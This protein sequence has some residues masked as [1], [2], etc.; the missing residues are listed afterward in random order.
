M[1]KDKHIKDNNAPV[2]PDIYGNIIFWLLM[3]AI[4]LVPL[5]F[6]IKSYDQFEMPKLTLL[7]ILTSLMLGTWL[8]K[9][10]SEGRIEY[11][12]MPLD[13]PMLLWALMNIVTT[14]TSFSPHLSFRGE[15][16]NFAGS[17]S[18]LNYVA[19]YFI[20]TQFIKTKKQVNYAALT[21][22]LS[23]LFITVYSLMQFAGFDFI[24]WSDAS[25][26]KGRYFASMGNPNFLGAFI[27]MVIPLTVAFFIQAAKAGKKGYMALLGLLFVGEYIALF[28]TQSRGPF[29][30][31]VFSMAV[32]LIY[33]IKVFLKNSS[34]NSGGLLKAIVSHKIW[35]AAVSAVL[36]IAV[37][38][39]LTAG[40]DATNRIV[41][42]IADIPGSLQQSRLHIWIPAVKMIKDRPVFGYGV[43]TFKAVFP[44]YEGSDF[45]QID[46]A[47]VS[48]RTAH[49]EPLNIAAT[50]GLISLGIYLMMIWLYLLSWYRSFKRIEEYNYR[51][52]SLGF[53]AASVGYLVQNMFSFGVA[54]INTTF[55]LIMAIH[56]L[57]YAAVK[58]VPA[59]VIKLYDREKAGFFAPALMCG[60]AV[61]SVFLCFKAYNVYSADVNYNMGKLY[62]SLHNRWDL[63]VK[64]HE[65]SVEKCP[66]EVKYHVYLGLAYERLAMMYQ[67]KESKVKLLLMAEKAYKRGSELNSMNAYYWGNLGRV[68]TLLGEIQDPKY[69]TLAEEDYIQA[70]K[71]APVT[72]LFYN[73]L[74]DLYLKTGRGDK[75]MPMLEK[76]EMYDKQLAAT[77]N[78]TLGN[79]LFGNRDYTNAL[80]HYKRSFEFKPDFYECLYNIGVT[81]AT[82]GQKQEAIAALNELLLKKPDFKQREDAEK[83]LKDLKK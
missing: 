78:F 53:F 54:A 31:F 24:K 49:N 79:I 10:F 26:I 2:K 48:S 13:I 74:L 3:A 4:F 7:R 28:G 72:A 19:L 51:I 80:Y 38:L 76:I 82:L 68:H 64:Q 18:N 43:D 6:N 40:K 73:N 56:A 34:Q 57:D 65:L 70:V 45:A 11:K 42:S 71:R 61:L 12:P 35:I 16:E 37:I 36:A 69:F 29:L 46:G 5:Y 77:A 39:S 75:I 30:G 55:Y 83:I 81:A 20:A 52:L 67:D 15:Y 60:A 66:G 32:F 17:L 8:V 62:G 23:G 63:A 14:F 47:N 1:A 33:G 44:A 59:A 27:I 58:R 41:S 25:V 9:I 21:I 22:A 50:M